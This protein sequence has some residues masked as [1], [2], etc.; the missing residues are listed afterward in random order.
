MHPVHANTN[1]L[2]H[3]YKHPNAW[4]PMHMLYFLTALD[5][6]MS[7]NMFWG[8][9]NANKITQIQKYTKGKVQKKN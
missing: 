6:G 7:E 8:V 3:K 4:K 5:T 2:I 1:T 9:I